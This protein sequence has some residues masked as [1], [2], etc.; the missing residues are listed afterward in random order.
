MCYCDAV[1]YY[2]I[3]IINASYVLCNEQIE[4]RHDPSHEVCLPNNMIKEK[5]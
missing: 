4:A 3:A 2:T 5:R 1:I